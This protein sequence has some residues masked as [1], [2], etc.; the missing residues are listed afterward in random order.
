[1]K[2]EEEEVKE[3]GMEKFREEQVEKGNR[4][5]RGIGKRE[6]EE[7]EEVTLVRLITF[8][9]HVAAPVPLL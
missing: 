6:G 4:W 1:M 9:L 3:E 2:E 5:M 7:I 8:Y